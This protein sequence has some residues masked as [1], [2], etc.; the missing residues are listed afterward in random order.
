M[1]QVTLHM[2]KPELMIN[3][4]TGGMDGQLEQ[5]RKMLVDG[6]YEAVVIDVND[7]RYETVEDVAEE[8]FDLTNNPSRQTAREYVYGR[9]RSLSVGDIVEAKGEKQLCCSFSW[10][11][12]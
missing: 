4:Y 8:M 7:D 9:G 11:A 1:A 6:G 5:A 3:M 2:L 10:K 12:I